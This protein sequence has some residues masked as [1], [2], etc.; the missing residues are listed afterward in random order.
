MQQVVW[1]WCSHLLSGRCGKWRGPFVVT[2]LDKGDDSR[3]CDRNSIRAGVGSILF[4]VFLKVR[5]LLAE[6]LT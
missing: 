5:W 6:R 3:A 4:G 1:G 2:K